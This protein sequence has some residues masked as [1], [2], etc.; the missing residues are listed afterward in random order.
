MEKMRFQEIH[1]FHDS[2]GFSFHQKCSTVFKTCNILFGEHRSPFP[3]PSTFFASRLGV[4]GA[5]LLGAYGA[6]I[7]LLKQKRRRG[8]GLG[9]KPGKCG[10]MS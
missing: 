7:L 6:S 2:V 4:F 5:S 9:L 3:T 10:Q 1:F 8:W